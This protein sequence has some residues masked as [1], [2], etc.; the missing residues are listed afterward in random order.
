MAHPG[1]L[2]GSSDQKRM[3]VVTRTRLPWPR[4]ANA[5]RTTEKGQAPRPRHPQ[6]R[7]RVLKDA[8]RGRAEDI[9]GSEHW[10]NPLGLQARKVTNNETERR[11]N[12]GRAVFC[13]DVLSNPTN[14]HAGHGA[15]H[16][17]QNRAKL[18]QTTR[19]VGLHTSVLTWGWLD[20]CCESPHPRP[21]PWPLRPRPLP[22]PR[23]LYVPP[24]M[25]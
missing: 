8:P 21:L 19:A 20:D 15:R 16:Q 7:P 11:T 14:T 5:P 18:L 25:L 23:R 24:G 13:E 22:R 3:L 1:L 10:G 6:T 4:P 17:H 12:T 2:D 9:T